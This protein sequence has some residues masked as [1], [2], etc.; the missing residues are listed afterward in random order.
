MRTAPVG[1]HC[2]ECVAQKNNRVY[3]RANIA[4]LNDPLVTKAL[5]AINLAIFVLTLTDGGGR[6]P[7]S[8]LFQKG[9]L[10]A[11]G[12][13]RT[14]ELIGVDFGEWYR[15]FTSGFLHVDLMHVG[16]NMYL[17]YVLGTS[18][19]P[20]LGHL[21]FAL[22]YFTSLV[23]GSFAVLWLSPLTPTVGASGAVFGLMAAMLVAQRAAGMKPWQSSIG[24]LVAIN[25]VFTFVQPNVSIGGHI[26]G[27][28]GGA[29]SGAIL[30]YLPL[31]A[32]PER[33]AQ[34]RNL[35]TVLVAAL[36]IAGFIGSIWIAGDWVQK[37]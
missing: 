28:I 24:I 23:A 8:G 6:A 12:I 1:F 19:E 18:I 10:I 29:I 11:A 25:L 2:P 7:A 37:V 13:T 22:L 5:V 16:F 3:T 15:I 36:L 30:V 35:A 26:G 21:R 32:T 27:L 9:R 14:Q 34:A 33:R 31:R 17:L 4:Q 20:A